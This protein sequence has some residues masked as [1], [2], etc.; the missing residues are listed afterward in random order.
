MLTSRDAIVA[1]CKLCT[2]TCKERGISIDFEKCLMLD[3]NRVNCWRLSLALGEDGLVPLQT[4]DNRSKM[5]S[6]SSILLS[7]YSKFNDS[8]SF[9][10]KALYSKI[11]LCHP[12][13]AVISDYAYDVVLDSLLKNGA[14]FTYI[15]KETKKSFDDQEKRLSV[16]LRK[17][18]ADLYAAYKVDHK[19]TLAECQKK[20]DELYKLDNLKRSQ[21]PR[22]ETEIVFCPIGKANAEELMVWCDLS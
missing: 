7:F 17:N 21:L 5:L 3:D 1:I 4:I 14:K 16:E 19:M 10:R 20:I 18:I 13:N 9:E 11:C 8:I 12:Q 22:Y 15:D 6:N 2:K